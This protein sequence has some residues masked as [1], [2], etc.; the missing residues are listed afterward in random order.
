[1][2]LAEIRND[3][4]TTPTTQLRS[5]ILLDFL[6][7]LFLFAT[8]SNKHGSRCTRFVTTGARP[9]MRNA[10]EVDAA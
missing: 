9:D 6:I 2:H 10:E 5:I 1:L 7:V 8:E 4:L 3:Y